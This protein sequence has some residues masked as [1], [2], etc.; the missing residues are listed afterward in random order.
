MSNTTLVLRLF[1]ITACLISMVAMGLGFFRYHKYWN[2]KTRDYWFGRLMWCIVGIT[3]CT[4]AIIRNTSFRYSI[5][6]FIVAAA[7][8]LKGV[9]TP[10]EWGTPREA[11]AKQDALK[12]HAPRLAHLP[13]A[14]WP[15]NRCVARRENRSRCDL[16]RGHEGDHV[17][18]RGVSG[19]W[20]WSTK[21][22]D[23]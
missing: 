10:G 2:E 20:P 9:L 21:F 14:T 15:W 22:T 16:R 19:D 8:T 13:W 3:G 7:V 5:V 17:L 4:E 23:S 1:V 6:F 11:L 18:E 12:V